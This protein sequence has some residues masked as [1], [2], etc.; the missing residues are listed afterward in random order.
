MYRSVSDD[1]TA[2]EK[3]LNKRNTW[4]YSKRQDEKYWL[5]QLKMPM[6]MFRAEK[7]NP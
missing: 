7:V 3:N 6:A 5:N 4:I 2:L 1:L